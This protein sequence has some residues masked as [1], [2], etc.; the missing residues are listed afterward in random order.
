M[1]LITTI[2]HTGTHNM[3]ASS[4]SPKRSA[5]WASNGGSMADG[6]V[7]CNLAWKGRATHLYHVR[8]FYSNYFGMD[9]NHPCTWSFLFWRYLNIISPILCH[10]QIFVGELGSRRIALAKRS[11][12]GRLPKVLARA[13][14]SGR[15]ICRIGRIPSTI[16][17]NLSMNL[18][19]FKYDQVCF[20]FCFGFC[21]W[22]ISSKV[23]RWPGLPLGPWS[24]R[25]TWHRLD[26]GEAPLEVPFDITTLGQIYPLCRL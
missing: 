1:I 16:S 21:F 24:R 7:L 10:V 8:R 15:Q 6:N 14:W 12:R 20:G 3:C 19:S 18:R 5:A 25:Q 4:E 2:I 9:W 26:L 22:R 13:T 23:A 17:E 11:W